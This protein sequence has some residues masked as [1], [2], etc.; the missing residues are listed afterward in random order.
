M[1]GNF[2]TWLITGG[3]GFIGSNFILGLRAERVAHIINLDKITYGG[4][5][6]NLESLRDDPDHFFVP[7]PLY[8]DGQNISGGET[9]NIGGGSELTNLAVVTAI[10]ELL[11]E[12]RPNSPLIP[13]TSLITFVKDRPGHDRRYALDTTK[14]AGELG[15][16]PQEIFSSGLS[17]TVRWY[18]EHQDW[19]ESVQTGAYQE[20]LQMHY[21]AT[22]EALV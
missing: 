14:I 11:D 3:A 4:N 7:L 8:G 13:H 9:Y 20:W 5:L 21:G 19:V 10:C 6:R 1:R 17:A 15:W 22:S 2:P 18:L 12:L 16:R